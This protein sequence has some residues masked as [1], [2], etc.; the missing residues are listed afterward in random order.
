VG[1]ARAA[2]PQPYRCRGQHHGKTL[3]RS[4]ETDNISRL[5]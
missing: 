3:S 4:A 2:L 1:V 5:R